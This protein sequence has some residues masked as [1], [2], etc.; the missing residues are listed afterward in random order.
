[1]LE[2]LI[3]MTAGEVGPC[4]AGF[5]EFRDMPKL[6]EALIIR[7]LAMRGSANRTAELLSWLLLLYN[8][9]VIPSLNYTDYM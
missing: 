6:R 4:H 5:G 2:Y 9:A 8:K 1:M 7:F 3:G